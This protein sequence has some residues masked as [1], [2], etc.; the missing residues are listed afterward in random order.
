MLNEEID[1]IIRRLNE[2][3]L[4]EGLETLSEEQKQS[5]LEQLKRLPLETLLEQRQILENKTPN[6]NLER[7]QNY[8]IVDNPLTKKRT[9][10]KKMGCLVLAGG[11]GSR[12]ASPT[13]KALFP[14]T[15]IR[16]QTLLG[17]LCERTKAASEICGAPL[18][19]CI[20]TST[21]NHKLIE[22]YLKENHF[23]GLEKSQVVLLCQN[24]LPFLNDAGH[25]MLEKPGVVAEGPDGNGDALNLFVKSPIYTNW[26]S[27]G[28]ET[29]NIVPIDNPLADPFD[30]ILYDLH[31]SSK[32]EISIKAIFRL[33]PQEKVGIIGMEKE[34]VSVAEYSELPKDS[35]E[36]S[37]ASIS[38]FC[39]DLFF[40]KQ[41]SPYT[42]PLHLARKKAPI[43]SQ[44]E[45]VCQKEIWKYE[46]FIFD[47]FPLASKTKV[48]VFPRDETYAPLKNGSGEKGPEDVQK[49][50]LDYDRKVFFHKTGKH[51]PQEPFELD[52]R[53]YYQSPLVSAPPLVLDS[54]L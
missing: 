40:L 38:L 6:R 12:L 36:F 21:Q 42:I 45:G 29:L 30:P 46:R 18:P 16:K 53:L 11:L 1:H 5:F 2:P 7:L 23:F 26:Q 4:K 48:F 9:L 41:I 34:N 10:S 39:I 22:A 47:L 52:P 15:V 37:I 35:H 31:T 24:T 19:L 43:F 51:P 32:A 8:E 28:I 20:L 50:V 44:K 33:D 49:A 3:H 17:R 14:F 54:N 13:P 27:Q 25:W